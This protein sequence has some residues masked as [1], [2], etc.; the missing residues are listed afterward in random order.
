MKARAESAGPGESVELQGLGE[1]RVVRVERTAGALVQL[2]GG[3]GVAA[4]SNTAQD[5]ADAPS[6]ELGTPI[7]FSC[8]RRRRRHRARRA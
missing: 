7:E 1:L 3:G 2:G 6:R 4:R 8:S 5:T